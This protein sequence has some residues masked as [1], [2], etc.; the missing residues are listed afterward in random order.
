MG[1]PT[2][3]LAPT[4]RLTRSSRIKNTAGN[5]S[6]IRVGENTIVAGE[7]FTFRHGGQIAI[8]D[9][10]YV[11]EGTRIWSAGSISIGDRVLIAHNVNIFDSTTHPVDATL[12]HQQFRAIATTGHPAQIA[13]DEK[14]VHIG[15]D[16]WIGA[17][18]IILRGVTIGEG[19]VVGAGAVVTRDVE[20]W[21]MVAGNPAQKLRDI[22]P[23]ERRSE[24]GTRTP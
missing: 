3:V 24:A 23:A 7:L 9:W 21:T 20:A 16:A 2:C 13:L 15:N 10:C 14:P 1:R 6:R 19:A 5:S 17:G 12:R 4:A 11:G 22:D 8:G 18:A